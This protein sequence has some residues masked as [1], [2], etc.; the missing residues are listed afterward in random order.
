MRVG[1]DAT[2]LLGVRTGVGH[3]VAELI[4]ALATRPDPPELRLVP[5]TLRGAGALP[6]RLPAGLPT[7]LVSCRAR[8]VPARVLRALWA[9][10]PLPPVEWL[11]GRVDV[12][13]AT[14]FVLPPRSRAAG[15][16]TVHDLSFLH[17]PEWVTPDSRR[18]R[19]LVP[20]SLAGADV[21]CTPT[22][23]VAEQV[24]EAYRID[25]GRLA[26]TPLG[27]SAGWF[28]VDPPGPA[29][30]TA[31]RL[32]DRYLLFVGTLEPRKNLPG[33]LTAY[34]DLLAADRQL[35]PLV[36]A[37]P[38]GW[39][40]TLATDRLPADRVLTTGYL[41]PATLRAAVAGAACL[42][43]P[44]HDE[45]FGLPALEALATGTP[46][47]ASDLPALREVLGGQAR[48]ADPGDPAALASALAATLAD[49][50]PTDRDARREHARAWTWR[51]CA[52]ATLAAYRQAL[53]RS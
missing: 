51:R 46:V 25:P 10:G 29:W 36:L 13:H 8:P 4:G 32:P 40:P 53:D 15:V 24:A 39:G 31:H 16:V 50:G 35:P 41:E 52:E 27:V 26:V 12:F 5:F 48:Y 21:V 1:V 18:Y 7:G 17:H 45:G 2:P 49:G 47:V 3:Y 34:A 19:R 14:N 43:V 6:G 28:T 20:R 44:S 37:G 11:A 23:A 42:V 38:A 9:R 33:L 30:R 22:Q